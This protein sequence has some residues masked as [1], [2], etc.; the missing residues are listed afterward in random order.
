MQKIR[1]VLIFIVLIASAFLITNT[2]MANKK[3]PVPDAWP[4]LEGATVIYRNDCAK[5]TEKFDVV[6]AKTGEIVS[7]R[8]VEGNAKRKE[9]SYQGI[10]VIKGVA[11]GNLS[12]KKYAAALKKNNQ[13]WN[14]T[15]YRIVRN[16]KKRASLNQL[17]E[18]AYALAHKG[19][20]TP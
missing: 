9:M 17:L 19:S 18:L 3:A 15:S 16:D 11:F 6:Q 8:K 4:S 5:C 13:S 1:G 20:D 7:A 12:E 14:G 2:G 10:V